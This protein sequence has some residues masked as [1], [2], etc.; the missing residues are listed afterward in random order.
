MTN[1]KTRALLERASIWLE[2]HN[3]SDAM[4]VT[5]ADGVVRA[6]LGSLSEGAALLLGASTDVMTTDSGNY[7]HYEGTVDG[8][9][10]VVLEPLT[11]V[12]QV[13]ADLAR[14]ARGQ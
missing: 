1:D 10:V 13:A 11:P 3:V 9:V 6:H 14:L 8:V 4:S 12:V 2:T 7:R 5:I